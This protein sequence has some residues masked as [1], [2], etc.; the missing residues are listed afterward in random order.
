[1]ANAVNTFQNPDFA[2]PQTVQA[3]AEA[4]LKKAVASDNAPTAITA[5]L[6]ISTAKTKIDRGSLAEAIA[7]A[8]STAALFKNSEYAPVFDLLTARLY[9]RYY[10]NNSWTFDRRELPLEPRP[11][12]VSEWSGD[13]FKAVIADLCARAAEGASARLRDVPLAKGDEFLTYDKL[14]AEFYPS[15]YDF[16]LEAATNLVTSTQNNEEGLKFFRRYATRPDCRATEALWAFREAQLSP[17]TQAALK[18][19]ID[20]HNPYSS[21]SLKAYAAGLALPTSIHDDTEDILDVDGTALQQYTPQDKIAEIDSAVKLMREFVAKYP[22]LAFGEALK[23]QIERLCAPT[24]RVHS[25][26]LTAPLSELPLTVVNVNSTHYF[27]N[28]FKLPAH[29]TSRRDLKNYLERSAPVR[30]IEVRSEAGAKAPFREDTTLTVTLPEAGRYIIVPQQAGK[31]SYDSWYSRVQCVPVLPMA[32]DNVEKP[33][34]IVSDPVTGAPV[35]GASV[36][37]VY[38]K[39]QSAAVSTDADGVAYPDMKHDGRLRVTT[40]GDRKSVV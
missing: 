3:N 14:S 26:N 15:L 25:A 17:D 33:A 9:Y 22:S 36:A 29:I 16:V 21:L 23:Q 10:R 13:Q 20:I 11:A 24:V 4:A 40:K 28:V 19:N 31:K 8:D 1:M 5:L 6:Q 37:M 27:I 39:T 12:D 35:K 7:L 30:R 32:I 34:V 38:N 18:K 2:F